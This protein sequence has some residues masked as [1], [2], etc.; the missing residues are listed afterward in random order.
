MS[1]LRKHVADGSCR[2]KRDQKRER[3]TP[4]SDDDDFVGLHTKKKKGHSAKREENLKYND[5]Q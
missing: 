3:H 1:E 4:T 5:M 2:K